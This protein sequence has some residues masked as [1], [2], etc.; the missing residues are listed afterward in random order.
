ME[1]T[2]FPKVKVEEL[3]HQNGLAQGWK[4]LILGSEKVRNALET[5]ISKLHECRFTLTPLSRHVLRAFSYCEPGDIKVIIIG[6]SPIT[7]TRPNGEG[8][9]IRQATGLAFSAERYE[10]EFSSY[11]AINK[12]HQAL[13]GAEIL[14]KDTVYFCG[15][16]QWAERG[17]LLL[18][19]ALTV[20]LYDGGPAQIHFHCQI[21]QN[22]LRD[23][24][25]EWLIKRPPKHDLHVMLWGHGQNTNPNFAKTLWDGIDSKRVKCTIFEA[26]HPTFPK[27]NN[28]FSDLAT[29]HFQQLPDCKDLFKC[30]SKE[31]PNA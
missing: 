15:H 13:K 26:H 31:H 29:E 17:I 18:N 16:Q 28:N 2:K 6:T 27:E 3:L 24:L 1:E 25:N 11:Q 21:W 22:F 8:K 12:V 20:P 4:D 5:V 10:N 23:L 9:D 30:S 7:D 19:S 14:D